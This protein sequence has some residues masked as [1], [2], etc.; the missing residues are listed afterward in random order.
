MT[1]AQTIREARLAAG[2]TQEAAARKLGVSLTSW[3]RWEQGVSLP[4]LQ[5]I[6]PIADVLG[7]EP[8][9]LL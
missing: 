1:T 2:L 9:K 6:R 7:I 3:C 8:E 5:N 4:K